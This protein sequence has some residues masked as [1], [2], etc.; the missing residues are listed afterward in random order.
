MPHYH[1]STC[2]HEWDGTKDLKINETCD[3]CGAGNP[4]ILEEITPFEQFCKKMLDNIKNGKNL[5]D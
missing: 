2:H 3:W 4:V 1:C 5:L